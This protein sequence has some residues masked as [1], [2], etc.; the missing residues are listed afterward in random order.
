MAFVQFHSFAR[1]P[2]L[3]LVCFRQEPMSSE[4]NYIT[5]LQYISAIIQYKTFFFLLKCKEQI[6]TLKYSYPFFKNFK[7]IKYASNKSGAFS[8]WLSIKN[9]YFCSRVSPVRPAPAESPQGRKAARVGG[10]SG[11]TQVAYPFF[12]FFYGVLEK[13]LH[14]KKLIVYFAPLN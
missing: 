7:Q 6:V 11:A 1:N 3:R 5:E 4:L 10:C 13:G 12:S 2:V 8:L 14:N 9:F